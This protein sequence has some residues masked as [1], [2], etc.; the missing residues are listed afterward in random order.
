M[1][2]AQGKNGFEYVGHVA[3]AQPVLAVIAVSGGTQAVVSP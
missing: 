2:S 1:F 3:S